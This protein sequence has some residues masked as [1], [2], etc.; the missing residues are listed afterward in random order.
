M[1]KFKLKQI[2][3]AI[4]LAAMPFAAN[5]A[6]LGKLT[7]VSGLGEPLSAEIELLST[8]AEELSSLTAAIAPEEAYSVQ[9]V[10]RT[11]IHNSIK[12]EVVRRP[13]GNPILKLSTRQPISDPFLDMLIQ[14][15]WS[16]G[17]L[18][19]EYT[20]LLDPPGYTNQTPASP[21]SPATATSIGGTESDVS[22]LPPLQEQ[23]PPDSAT[24]SRSGKSSGKKKSAGTK[25]K[26]APVVTEDVP[27]SE[28]SGLDHSTARG[29]TL[30]AIAQQ[31]KVEGVSLDQMLVGLYR[32]NKE[33]FSGGN[34]NRLKV[35]Q[36]VR[37]PSAEELQSIPRAEASQEVRVQTA[38]WQAYR[39]KLAGI[40]AE[41]TGGSEESGNQA[42]GGKI[43]APAEDKAAAAPTGPRDVVKLSK[44]DTA[45]DKKAA[46]GDAKAMQDKLNSLQEEVTARE[47]GLK[48]ADERTAMLEKQIADMQKLLAVKNQTMADAQKSAATQN[49]AKPEAAAPVTPEPAKTE[50]PTAPAPVAVEPAAPAEAAPAAAPVAPP[51][52]EVKK[53]EAAPEKKPA[54]VAAAPA[55]A[56]EEP[57][58][59]DF[60]FENPIILGAL[61]GIVLLFGGWFF[62]RNRRKH[63]L[64]GFEQGI[65]TSGGLKANT[66]FGNTTGGTVDTGDTSFLTDF[67]QSSG[68]MIDTH[69]VDPIAEAEVY[70]AY[71]RDSQAEEIL[72]D[73]IS[74]E[75][76]RYE[77]HL[78]LLEI[79]ASRKD[80][81]GFETLAGEL[82]AQLGSTDPVWAK[83]AEIGH[84]L[85]PSNPLYQASA[86]AAGV[87]AVAASS[88]LEASDFADAEVMTESS[89]DFS[90]DADEPAPQAAAENTES[91]GSLDF[92]LGM[93]EPAVEPVNE[94]AADPAPIE[95]VSM[96]TALDSGPTISMDMNEPTAGLD[97]Q[98]D[99]PEQ[100]AES[101]NQ[102]DMAD[103]GTLPSFDEPAAAPALGMD[104]SESPAPEDTVQLD[105][106]DF[107]NTM[108]NLEAS[109]FDLPVVEPAS[110]DVKEDADLTEI[111]FDLPEMPAATTSLAEAEQ[112]IS[113]DMQD[114]DKTMLIQPEAAQEISFEPVAEA[115]NVLDLNFGELEATPAEASVEA[116]VAAPA[117]PPELDLSG[118]SLDLGD[119]PAPADS[120]SVVDNAISA[121]FGEFEA[122]T[123][124]ESDEVNT[125]L[126]LVTA[127]MEIGDN[128]GARE[129]LD[130]VMKEGGPKQLA[131]AKEILAT[132]G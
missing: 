65:L 112:T 12:I 55:P 4:C 122:S 17:R 98:L 96:S 114:F 100:A 60:L 37:I 126:D 1:H 13:N 23:V 73:A 10:E 120:S 93:G 92:D 101:N 113:M 124:E 36:I 27:A 111:S 72:K 20:V 74:K 71:G 131:R 48:E 125:K 99:L 68:G 69:D 110:V 132:I 14:V 90:L 118:I 61:G 50:T 104:L 16:T 117:N 45:T 95:V 70:M 109:T 107:G 30:S 97:F 129:L 19:R 121:D 119:V 123:Q 80:T 67:S 108:P 44:S 40:V 62:M 86:V 7:V 8:T 38:D 28:G 18:L 5:A 32:A 127:Y 43:S 115:D 58:L 51:V 78:K 56:A 42:T 49:Q 91:A 25:S 63:N 82:Y 89:L 22:K 9:G 88:Q 53:P 34:M 35:G 116:A 59:L 11:A 76:K 77:L 105:V 102:L 87:T 15:D 81:S 24:D 85:E 46:A 84:K 103:L 57:G 41:S 66:V 6:G 26:P 106:T 54:A 33:A 39:N 52:A 79:L 2:S 29:D 130:E 47:K 94:V 3:L 21:S 128:E 31:N 64:D 75:P 83:V